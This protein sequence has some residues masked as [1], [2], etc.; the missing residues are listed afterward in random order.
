MAAAALAP[1]GAAA[2]LADLRAVA[3]SNLA[4]R[5]MPMMIPVTAPLGSACSLQR[6][7]RARPRRSGV[8]PAG[9]P[10]TGNV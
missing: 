7:G 1:A 10:P 9:A 3:L 6:A 4:L 5:R 8:G 2:A